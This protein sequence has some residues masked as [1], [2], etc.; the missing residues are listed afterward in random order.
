MSFKDQV[1]IVTGS[2]QGIGRAYALEL[3]KEG[4]TV[5]IADLNEARGKNVENEIR[6]AG[7]KGKFIQVDLGSR[8]SI[9][10]L[11]DEV[12]KEFGRIDILV[13]NAA[14]FSTIK[15]KPFEE[16]SIEEWDAVLNVN[17]TAM[18]SI[19]QAVVPHMRKQKYGRIVN[20]SSSTI[21]SGK[22]F[23]IHY[24][25]SKAGVVGFTRALAREVGEDNITVNTLSPGATETEIER[26][27]VTK[28]QAELNM[29]TQCIKRKGE[30]DDLVGMVMY[31]VSRKASFI[32]GQFIN[33]DG[34]KMMY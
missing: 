19:S 5:I 24:V 34:G 29:K 15:L 16:I 18:F 9:L 26:E 31:L 14:I 12:A 6:Q 8:E 21:L 7:Q 10:S 17:L 23:Y 28:E 25:S 27:T 22:P 33:V 30:P 11:V 13:N 1:A 4:A 32:T 20:V 2:G 3:A